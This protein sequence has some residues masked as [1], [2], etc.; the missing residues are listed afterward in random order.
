ME[1]QKA[2][3]TIHSMTTAKPIV[4]AIALA[5]LIVTGLTGASQAGSSSLV[6]S[7]I[8]AGTKS[9]STQGSWLVAPR[10]G[11]ADSGAYIPKPCTPTCL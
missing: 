7:T 3:Q 2:S 1:A 5:A 9:P 10:I 6:G 11:K 4:T 8:S